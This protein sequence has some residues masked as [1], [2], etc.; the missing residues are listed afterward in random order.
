MGRVA[1]AFAVAVF[2]FPLFILL[3]G[4]P[5]AWGGALRVGAVSTG[6][7][8]GL[9]VPA[10][11]FFR[12][13][14]WWRLWQF[15]AGGGLGGGLCALFFVK[16]ADPNFP[17]FVAVFVIGGGVHAT[18]FWLVAAWRNPELTEPRQYCLPGGVS[19]RVVR[20]LLSGIKR[21]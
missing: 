3:S 5:D 11:L 8:L 19:Y 18:L 1:L 7:V 13:R 21:D 20:G 12:C 6:G 16:P 4:S 15:V 2:A 14:G 17:L 9:G 10:F